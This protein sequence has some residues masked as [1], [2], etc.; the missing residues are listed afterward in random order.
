MEVA[1]RQTTLPNYDLFPPLPLDTD[2]PV[3]LSSNDPASTAPTLLFDPPI[4]TP[5][6][7]SVESHECP[8][9]QV[10]LLAFGE[11]ACPVCYRPQD[12]LSE[13]LLTTHSEA[14]NA[15]LRDLADENDST[16]PEY[17]ERVVPKEPAMYAEVTVDAP[18]ERFDATDSRECNGCGDM[19]S[20]SFARVFGWEDGTIF[21]RECQPRSERFTNDPARK[22]G[23]Y[24]APENVTGTDNPRYNR[25]PGAEVS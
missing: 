1:S 18:G 24:S 21:C 22:Y 14:V 23:S 20:A 13:H 9:E 3:Y 4:P 12:N 2:P 7:R 6:K 19:V 16:K 15:R 5:P 17:A 11:D 10:T 8:G 25:D